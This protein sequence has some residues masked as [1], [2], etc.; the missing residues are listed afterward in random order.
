MK[1]AEFSGVRSQ[2]YKE[3][4][5]DYPNA[6]QM[7]YEVMAEYL[8]PKSG[9]HILEVGAGS[10]FF[11]GHIADAVGPE[12]TLTVSDPSDEQLEAVKE[13]NRG[14]IKL[15][16]VGAQELDKF[17]DRYF[18]AIWSFGAI[19]HCFE[20]TKA[21]THFYRLLKPDGRLVIV[22]V[23]AES[24]LAKHFDDKVAKYCATGHEVAFM[25]H[26]YMKSLCS[27]A[28]FDQP[29]IHDLPI[30]WVFENKDD[31]GNFLYK[32]HAMTKTTIEECLKGADEILGIKERHG[33]YYLNWPLTV[34]LVKK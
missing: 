28:G 26:E 33:K 5:R 22:D 8:S 15:I 31:I 30:E 14:N 34:L 3:A 16:K 21:F 24:E 12:G 18:D 4:L 19:H 6:R 29:E 32:L 7:D 1:K 17:G 13:L 23:L 11:S 9:E 25:S 10:G 2:L 20:K 27:L